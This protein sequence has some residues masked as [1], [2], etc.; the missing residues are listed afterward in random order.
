MELVEIDPVPGLLL[1]EGGLNGHG[2]CLGLT[3]GM[4]ELFIVP[5]ARSFEPPESIVE[6]FLGSLLREGDVVDLE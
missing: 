6:G 2:I 4:L 3:G 1:G 5:A